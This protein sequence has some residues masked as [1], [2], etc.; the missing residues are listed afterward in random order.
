[1]GLAQSPK[2]VTDGLV[3]YYDQNNI[4][5]LVGPA[6]QNLALTRAFNNNSGTGISIVGGYETVDVPQIG[7]SNTVFSN[8]QN[9]YTAFSPNSGDCCPSPL[10]YGNGFAV[11]PS[12]LYTYAIVYKV[13]SGYTSSNYMYRYEYTANGGS[14]VT[15][16]GVHN[17]SNR[18][19]LG[20]G[21]YWAW[22]TFTTQATTNWIA[23]HAAFYYRYSN[24]TDK[25]SV[26]KVLITRGDY[27][28]LHPKYWPEANTTRSTSQV[29]R[30]LANRNTITATNLTYASNGSFS[31]DRANSPTVATNLPMSSFPATSNFTLS[32]WLNIT[33]LPPAGNN[34]GVIF[35]ATYYSGA[36]IYWYSDGSTFTIYGY[37]RGNDAYRA[38]NSYTLPLNTVHHIV[39]TNDYFNGTLNLYVNGVLFSSVATATQ[40][41]NASVIGD[42]GN[43]GVNKPQIDGGGSNV[44]TYFTGTVYSASIYSKALTEAEVHQNF[45]ALRGRY[46]L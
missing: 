15:E 24:T 28:A 25:M 7:Q 32:A 19:H 23:Y 11:S 20:G 1:M 4:K 14:Y 42:A 13:N 36:A 46:G 22:G 2:V 44:Y 5:S 45:N 38:T 18:I 8:I 21:W 34:N 41:Y 16:G 3:F 17:D 9:N 31:F 40:Q 35:G 26:A 6:I 43:I 29:L 37:I 30:D 39:L 10:Y 12:T 27:T 33:A